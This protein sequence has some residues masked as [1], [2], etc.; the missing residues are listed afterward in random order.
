VRLWTMT[1]LAVMTKSPRKQRKSIDI[2]DFN[3]TSIC[4]CDAF[5]F[6]GKDAL[7]KSFSDLC[8]DDFAQVEPE[9][10]NEF[11]NS[12]SDLMNGE[13]SLEDKE[14]TGFN[15]EWL[16][17]TV[18]QESKSDEEKD[19]FN[20]GMASLFDSFNQLLKNQ[21]AFNKD[22]CSYLQK[23]MVRLKKVGR[24]ISLS[25]DYKPDCSGFTQGGTGRSSQSRSPR[26]PASLSIPLKESGADFLEHA[27]EGRNDG[28]RHSSRRKSRMESSE[29]PVAP[30]TPRSRSKSQRERNELKRRTLR[31]PGRA[32]R[33]KNDDDQTVV[34]R[35]SR[36]VESSPRKTTATRE[37]SEERRRLREK[38]SER[39][40]RAFSE[41]RS[42]KSSREAV[43]TMTPMPGELTSL[44]LSPQKPGKL[45][46]DS[47]SLS[48]HLV[49]PSPKA[50]KPGL[51]SRSGALSLSGSRHSKS[52]R[53]STSR[54]P[55]IDEVIRSSSRNTTPTTPRQ[56]VRRRR[57][58]SPTKSPQNRDGV[59]SSSILRSPKVSSSIK[60]LREVN[61][62][63]ST[64]ALTAT[65][66]SIATT[67]SYTS[68]KK[69][70]RKSVRGTT[71]SSRGTSIGPRSRLSARSQVRNS[72]MITQTVGAGRRKMT[73]SGAFETPKSGSSK[74]ARGIG[75]IQKLLS[76]EKHT[77]PF[78]F[79]DDESVFAPTVSSSTED[80]NYSMP[81][82]P[83]RKA[84]ISIACA[85]PGVY[86][87]AVPNSEHESKTSRMA[88]VTESDRHTKSRGS[89]VTLEVNN[90][91][92]GRSS[93]LSRSSRGRSNSAP[94]KKEE[95][96]LGD[97][98]S[99]VA[100]QNIGKTEHKEHSRYGGFQRRPSFASIQ[101]AII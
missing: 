84:S 64:S 95:K 89:S 100:I 12:L 42:P 25:A 61:M 32:L 34:S 9:M 10:K 18:G 62:G 3:N 33:S 79:L 44:Q 53:K 94:R 47:L 60:L 14:C 48:D 65:S 17:N 92:R 6:G 4:D 72:P 1:L 78:P 49:L 56:P 73:V 15:K 31:S 75:G 63:V 11:M 83:T 77:L 76:D 23:E 52:P 21:N 46:R 96:K 5:K 66:S 7:F 57:T 24:R 87:N 81:Q 101:S 85:L 58:A 54:R 43:R 26:K 74:L 2:N 67:G 45:R 90:G 38:S 55:K 41:R 68:P 28:S 50:S 27:L 13:G 86:S 93:S 35:Q 16:D 20:V 88:P 91:R 59:G 69:S 40:R 36:Q 22:E 70:P 39:R 97:F 8:D 80:S 98:M 99:R 37:K 29:V 19:N 71:S 30:K 51:S 82:R